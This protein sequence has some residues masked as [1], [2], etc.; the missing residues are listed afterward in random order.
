V[1]GDFVVIKLFSAVLFSAGA[2]LTVEVADVMVTILRGEEGGRILKPEQ[3]NGRNQQNAS[4]NKSEH[5]KDGIVTDASSRGSDR[6]KRAANR[7]DFEAILLGWALP[8]ST[9]NDRLSLVWGMRFIV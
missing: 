6:E 8:A 4:R 3:Q 2:T 7:F 5:S 9:A 1:L